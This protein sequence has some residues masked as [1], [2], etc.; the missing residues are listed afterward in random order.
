[1]DPLP[2]ADHLVDF[3]H[4]TH[5][6]KRATVA[7]FNLPDILWLREPQALAESGIEDAE[8]TFDDTGTICVVMFH[9]HRE[10]VQGRWPIAGE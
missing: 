6:G 4:R 10:N 9:W 1:L 2:A 3:G 5:L 8:F 7:R